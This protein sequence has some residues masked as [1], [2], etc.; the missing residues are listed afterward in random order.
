M[1]DSSSNPLSGVAVTFTAPASGASASLNGSSSV[2]VMTNSS[3]IA[4][5]PVPVANGVSG[6]YTVMASV[7]SLN[8]T[9]SF[10][11]TNTSGG[12]AV[13]L[14]PSTAIPAVP[15]DGDLSAVELGVKFMSTVNGTITG[16]RF[17]KGSQNTGTHTG[18]LWTS[19]GTLLATGAFTNETSSGWQQMTFSK[20]VSITA[21]TLYV[22]SY[23]TSTGFSYNSNYF[24][25]TY[26]NAPLEAPASS[27]VNGNGTYKYGVS[28]FPSGYSTYNYWVD[29]TFV[30]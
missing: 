2:A 14:W 20:A 8:S 18:S 30:P 5:S 27:Q 17:Y 23:H 3:G 11:L 19:T 26:T 21:N 25:S 13:S 22:A 28:Q 1:T 16:I 7:A 6:T 9:A 4:V 24:A 12:S 15:Y 29:V 10:T